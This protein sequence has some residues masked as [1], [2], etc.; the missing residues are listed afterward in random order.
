MIFGTHVVLYST[1]AEADRAFFRD[2]LGYQFVDAG[3][4]WLIFALPP[5][6]LA[7][8]PAD[9]T[10]GHEL[11]LMCDDVEAF[12]AELAQRDIECSELSTERWGSLTRLTLPGGGNLGVYQPSHPSPLVDP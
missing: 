1:D 9:T 8:H 6:E 3:H 10:G 11:F 5:A 7:V 4:D 12:I 2:V